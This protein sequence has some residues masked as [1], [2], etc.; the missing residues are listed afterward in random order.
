MLDGFLELLNGGKAAIEGE[1]TDTVF[2]KKN[3]MAINDFELT[4]SGDGSKKKKK[5]GKHGT[6]AE[7]DDDEDDENAG[8]SGKAGGS[9]SALS[10][11]RGGLFGSRPDLDAAAAG[12]KKRKFGLSFEI[13]KDIDAAGPELFMS[14]C[15]NATSNAVEFDQA[16]VTL[17]KASGKQSLVYLMFTF[18]EVRV[19]SYELE[20]QGG[21]KP[22]REKISFTF[23]TCTMQYRPQKSPGL[24]SAK[25]TG[26]D[27]DNSEVVGMD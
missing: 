15:Y 25:V 8:A 18:T 16:K 11:V 3:A 9:G 7:T 23:K 17:R 14:Y 5:K 2:G 19:A 20:S 21:D 22:L 13:S 27:F 26:W 6:A 10:K 24:A 12:T 1:T 4:S